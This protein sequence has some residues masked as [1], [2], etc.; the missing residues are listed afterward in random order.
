V[1]AAS[2]ALSSSACDCGRTNYEALHFPCGS[3]ADCVAPF[4]C[5]GGVCRRP[6]EDAGS[7]GATGGGA[8]GGQGGSGGA[9]GGAPADCQGY[10][11]GERCYVDGLASSQLRYPWNGTAG[12]APGLIVCAPS[13]PV[14]TLQHVPQPERC[15]GQDTDCDGVP[16][17]PSCPCL[18]GAACYLGPEL[19]VGA[20]PTAT[21]RWG[22]WNCAQPAGSQ[23]VG[24]VLPGAEICNG[25]DDD[26]DGLVDDAPATPACGVGVCASVSHACVDGGLAACDYGATP[27]PGYSTSELCNDGLDNDCNGLID[28]GCVCVLDAGIA[29]WTGPASACP[30]GA[31]CLG[32][33]RRGTEVCRALA[34]GGTG[35]G[36]CGGQVLPQSESSTLAC[37]DGQDDD[38][39][40]LTDCADPD[41]AGRSCSLTGVCVNG[42]CAMC[43]P[44]GGA[45][46]PFGETTCSDGVDNDCDGKIDCLDTGSCRGRTCGAG[47]T[48]ASDGGC[49]CSGNGGAPQAVETSCGDGA[50]N[51]CDGLADCKDP[52]CAAQSCGGPG[53]TCASGSCSCS[54]NGGTPQSPE[55]SCSDG[56]DNDCNGAVDC[57]DP[58]CS[59]VG[60][61]GRETNCDNGVDDDNDGLTDCADADCFHRRCDA[62]QRA[63]ICCGPY[64]ALPNTA[65]CKD[66]GHDSANCGQC[67]LSCLSGTSC[68]PV[69]D[70]THYSG[71]CSCPDNVDSEC[72]T[73]VGSGLVRQECNN[74][75]CSCSGG[76][77]RCGPTSQGSICVQV[78][79]AD[80]CGYQ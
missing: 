18:D 51:D 44:D 68:S 8:G 60:S 14:C 32:L 47:A 67:G 26:C 48:C 25:L 20:S 3:D 5:V 22:T 80:F 52:D 27:P 21:C 49:V 19:T 50:D 23:C 55:T 64:P 78:S 62:T 43:A 2:L 74:R 41:C 16:D 57:A 6:G 73:P 66:L 63:A 12:C 38:C 69:N 13:G 72:P 58:A 59:G 40:G 4:T 53:A 11:A 56:H 35:Y 70:G 42:A 1:L 30:Q 33:C 31:S 29:C 17:A 24:Q 75:Q 46:Q 37:N 34:D 45:A 71:L 54:G 65:S 61:C 79:G 28:D 76:A 7:G 77:D 15:D 39:D 9:T 10:D 36:S